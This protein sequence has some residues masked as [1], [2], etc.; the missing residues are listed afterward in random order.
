MA[1]SCVAL[2]KPDALY[3][4]KAV[5]ALDVSGAFPNLRMDRADEAC[6][7]KAGRFQHLLR[8]WY[9]SA[10]P[11]SFRRS[12][13]VQSFTTEIG[14]DQGDPL[15]AA[16]CCTALESALEKLRAA[17]QGLVPVAYLDDVYLVVPPVRLDQIM[18]LVDRLWSELGLKVNPRKLKI[19]SSNGRTTTPIPQA[20][21][22][23]LVESLR[24]LAQRLRVKIH[25]DGEPNVLGG[26]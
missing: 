1:K 25:R 7:S 6:G 19:W 3:P 15:A 10:T 26:W 23:S 14:V 5:L 11:K 18:S 17:E 12:D 22:S 21:R 13:D 9:S 24:V 8:Q 20:W 16:I 2:R 4:D